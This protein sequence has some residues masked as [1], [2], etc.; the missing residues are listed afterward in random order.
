MNDRNRIRVRERFKIRA[1]GIGVASFGL[2]V[3]LVLVAGASADP[4]QRLIEASCLDCHDSD[5]ET[6][7]DFNELTTDIGEDFKTWQ[8]VWERVRS[9]EM[10]PRKSSKPSP[11]ILGPALQSLESKLMEMSDEKQ[12][13]VGRVPARRLTKRELN[14]TLQD[15][16]QIQSEVTSGVPDEMNTA[17]FD[18]LGSAQRISSVHM[19]SYLD[20]AEAALFEAIRLGP[21]PYHRSSTDYSWL[22]AWHDKPVN[23]GGSVT[24]PLEGKEGV[25]LFRDVDYLTSFQFGVRSPGLH[26]L[27]FKA[28]A[29]QSETPITAKLIVKDSTGGARLIKAVDLSPG[30]PRVVTVET[31]LKPGDQPYLTLDTGGREPIGGIMQAGGVRQYQGPGLAIWSQ[32]AEGPLYRD[33]PPVRT[34][35]FFHGVALVSRPGDPS[36]PY[37]PEVGGDAAQAIESILS[38]WAPKVFRRPV[39]REELAPFNELATAALRDGRAFAEAIQVSFR[40]LLSSPQFLMFGGRAGPLDDDSLASRLSYFLWKSLPDDE[41]FSLAKAGRLTHPEVLSAQVDRM[42]ADEKAI[43]FIR[44]FLGQWLRLHQ[45]NATA[46]D[47]NLYPEYDEL[48]GDSMPQEPE[49]FFRE[50]VRE[51]RSLLNVIDSDFTYLNRRLARHYDLEDIDGQAFRRVSLPAG[52]PRGGML[53]MAAILKTTANGTVTS[54]VT[55]G[56]FVLANI[57]GTPPSPPPPS[58]GSIEPDTRGQTTIREILAAHRGLETCNRC[59]R[60]I[61]PPGFA[62]ESFDPIGGYREHYRASVGG[63]AAATFA[64]T[65]QRPYRKGQPV[66]PSGVTADGKPFSG[67]QEFKKHLLAEKDQ[68]ARN[69]VSQLVAYSTGGAIEFADRPRIERILEKTR[70]NEFPVGDLIREVVQ[71]QMFLNQ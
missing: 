50:L 65:G 57:L 32:T 30:T 67:I 20:A 40:S 10:P 15:L 22:E 17:G 35:T 69:F 28:A 42:L 68:I 41:L 14:Y 1:I 19:E 2:G 26:R 21:N 5:T 48:L 8:R 16:L 24:R 61:D 58:V 59:H 66:D 33:W 64:F 54:P 63:G 6:A 55:R 12:R 23:L 9:G 71:S 45:L 34:Q 4:M 51:N 36:G 70:R 60:E 62:L 38:H 52:G 27:R 18:T 13:S 44:D 25:V 3:A 49:R 53:T 29:Y 46:P 31:F 11:E 37:R 39:K 7:L 47:E 56:H 43:R